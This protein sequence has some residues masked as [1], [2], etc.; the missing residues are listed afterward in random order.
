LHD[1]HENLWQGRI[2]RAGLAAFIGHPAFGEVPFILEVPGA[3]GRGPDRL[4][5]GRAK[6]MRRRALAA[7]AA[8][9]TSPSVRP[10]L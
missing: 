10:I 5:I 1:K 9:Q 8:E 6:L 2:D 3:D 4:N 7:A